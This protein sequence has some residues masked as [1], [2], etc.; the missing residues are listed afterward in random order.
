MTQRGLVSR[1]NLAR[2]RRELARSEGLPCY[3]SGVTSLPADTGT[4]AVLA[5]LESDGYAVIEG[6]LGRDEAARINTELSDV[7]A[8]TPRGRNPFEGFHTRRIYALFAKTRSFDA[9][10]P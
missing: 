5:R 10:A 6:I 7:L 3:E 2:P 9:P 1:G 8:A 4:D